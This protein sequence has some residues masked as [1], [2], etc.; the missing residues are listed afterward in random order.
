VSNSNKYLVMSTRYGSTPRFTDWLTVSRNVTL[1]LTS[2]DR[3]RIKNPR[4]TEKVLEMNQ[5]ELHFGKLAFNKVFHSHY[6]LIQ[7]LRFSRDRRLKV[8]KIRKIITCFGWLF[9]NCKILLWE[10]NKHHFWID[11]SLFF[12]LHVT[13][14]KRYTIGLELSEVT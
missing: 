9:E 10:Q 12:P 13:F 1:T 6:I 11:Q 7:L 8:C 14:N 2:E 4:D 5:K 3:N